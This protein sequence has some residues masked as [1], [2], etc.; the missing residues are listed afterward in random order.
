MKNID[1][2][3]LISLSK[4]INKFLIGKNYDYLKRVRKTSI[5]DGLVFRLIYG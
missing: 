5:I 1:I 2:S 3:K 4:T